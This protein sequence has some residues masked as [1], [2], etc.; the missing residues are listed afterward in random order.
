[1]WKRLSCAKGSLFVAVA[2]AVMPTTVARAAAP[3]SEVTQNPDLR[4]L[5]ILLA[6]AEAELEAV[7]AEMTDVESKIA[8]LTARI[9]VMWAAYE[10]TGNPRILRSIDLLEQDLAEWE[11]RLA[12][13]RTR[14]AELEV[15]ISELK[16]QIAALLGPRW[17]TST[18]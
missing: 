4:Q 6:R 8:D 18:N 10:A 9:D 5:R 16:K 14:A 1:M 2:L 12:D 13:L 15:H 3:L 11:V 17:I 7:K